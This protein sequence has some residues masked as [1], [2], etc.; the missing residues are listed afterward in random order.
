MISSDSPS[1]LSRSFGSSDPM[2]KARI[3]STTEPQPMPS[4]K[5]PP[6]AWSRVTA[7]RASTA[8][9]RNESQRTSEPTRS[10]SVWPASHALVII[11]S[12]IG[13][14]SAPGGARWSMQAMP[15]K[16]AASAGAGALDQLVH[17]Q[18]HLRQEDPELERG[19]HRQTPRQRLSGAGMQIAATAPR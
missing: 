16:P 6:E 7:S 4:S 5:R 11:A 8:G 18:P 2:P 17:G 14:L 1:R 12:N 9:C 15:P 13:E 3:S 19:G 10:C